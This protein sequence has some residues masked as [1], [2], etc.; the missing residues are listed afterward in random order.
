MFGKKRYPMRLRE[1]V[2][3][4]I[5]CSPKTDPWGYHYCGRCNDHLTEE[6]YQ[7]L[8]SR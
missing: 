2:C 7:C 5:G 3:K 1:F 4:L 8:V 6:E